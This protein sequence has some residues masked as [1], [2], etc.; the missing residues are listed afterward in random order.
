MRLA[1]WR[2]S[3]VEPVMSEP[4]RRERKMTEFELEMDSLRKELKK[5]LGTVRRAVLPFWAMMMGPVA[6]KRRAA[7]F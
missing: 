6:S 5:A 7:W 1:R 3:L 2:D 4:V